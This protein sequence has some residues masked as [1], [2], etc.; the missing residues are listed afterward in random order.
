MGTWFCHAHSA[1]A[2]TP[3]EIQSAHDRNGSYLV[4]SLLED[5]PEL[6]SYRVWGG[7]ADEE[8]LLFED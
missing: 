6:R 1:A 2:M 3:Y 5:E 7:R 8:E 4:L